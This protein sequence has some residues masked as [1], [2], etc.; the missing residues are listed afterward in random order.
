ML[1]P[2]LFEGECWRNRNEF[3]HLAFGPCPVPYDKDM[4][5]SLIEI[6]N[7]GGDDKARLKIPKKCERC[8]Y[9]VWSDIRLFHCKAE[10]EIWG[11][12]DRGLEFSGVEMNNIKPLPPLQ[13]KIITGIGCGENAP[14]EA[15]NLAL[16][17]L[18]ISPDFRRILVVIEGDG[19]KITLDDINNVISKFENLVPH[20]YDLMLNGIYYE[21]PVMI[22]K[23]FVYI[24]QAP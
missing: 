4:T 11:S 16:R 23:V 9:L 24:V 6:E 19:D 12:F 3:M 18:T 8:R 22:D 7:R 10:G 21:K 13:F 14:V 15:A 17:D 1:C 5:P 20:D 2:N